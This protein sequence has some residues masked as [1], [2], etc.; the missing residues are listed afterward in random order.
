MKQIEQKIK[1]QQYYSL[2]D[3][4]KDVDLMFSNCQTYNEEASLLYQDSLTLQKYFHEELQKELKKHPELQE[5]EGGDGAKET[6]VAPSASASVGTPQPVTSA[7]RIKL[8]SSTSN[9]AKEAN[10]GSNGGSNGAQS[11]QE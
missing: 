1:K 7:T 10:G 11:D 2:G 5:L 3:M 9:G 4:R 6:S 8:I